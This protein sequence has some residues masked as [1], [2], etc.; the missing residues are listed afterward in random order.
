MLFFWLVVMAQL[1]D[2]KH[3]FKLWTIGFCIEIELHLQESLTSRKYE[4]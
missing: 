1:R 4:I 2:G 3:R